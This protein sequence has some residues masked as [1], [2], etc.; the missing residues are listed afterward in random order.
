MP[1]VPAVQLVMNRFR[2]LLLMADGLRNL[3]FRRR[4]VNK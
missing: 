2:K 1:L 4:N 3:R